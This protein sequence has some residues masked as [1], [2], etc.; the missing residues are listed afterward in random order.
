MV[1][2]P[3]PEF[4]IDEGAGIKVPDIRH[5][6]WEEGY[7]AGKEDRQVINQVI[8]FGNDL[9]MVFDESGEQMP[10]FQGRYEE[11]RAKILVHA[12]LSAEFFH[13]DWPVFGNAVSRKD[14]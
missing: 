2:N 11:V 7:R 5:Q 14:W 6:L 1:K 10:K 12:P 9:V 13:S 4:L 3:Y 8:K